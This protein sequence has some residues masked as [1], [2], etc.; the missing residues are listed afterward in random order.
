MM[1]FCHL[2]RMD[3]DFNTVIILSQITGCVN[4]EFAV[5]SPELQAKMKHPLLGYPSDGCF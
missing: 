4:T 3:V 5:L 2:G 1:T